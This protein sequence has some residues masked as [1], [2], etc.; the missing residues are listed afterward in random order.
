MDNVQANINL[1]DNN[2]G[3]DVTKF[4]LNS[5]WKLMLKFVNIVAFEFRFN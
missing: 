2:E 5:D 4:V 3:K 1:L